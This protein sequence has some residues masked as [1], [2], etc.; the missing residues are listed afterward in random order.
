[1]S[2]RNFFRNGFY[3]ERLDRGVCDS[4]LSVARSTHYIKTEDYRDVGYKP[5]LI[6][7]WDDLSEPIIAAH[8]CDNRLRVYWDT[9]RV[10]LSPLE[11]LY[12]AFDTGSALI[13]NFPSGHGMNWHSDTVDTTFIQMLVYLSG[14]TFTKEDGGYLQVSQ[15]KVNSEGVIDRN[16]LEPVA[17]IMPNNGTVVV[18]NNLMPTMVHRVEPLSAQKE[19]ITI[20][21][22]YG[23]MTNTLTRKRLQIM[24]GEIHA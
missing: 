17:E 2:L 22:R 19:R 14:D 20:V 3:I 9:F 23:F 16:G 11:A 10:F 18:M 4:L 12:G 6:A 21:F 13:N 24:K 8:N 15:G 7:E 1:M 5:P